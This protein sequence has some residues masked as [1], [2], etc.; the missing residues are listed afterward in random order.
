MAGYAVSFDPALRTRDGDEYS[1]FISAF[2]G[3]ADLGGLV[4]GLT[5][6]QTDLEPTLHSPG[7]N[8]AWLQNARYTR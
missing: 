5:R 2:G 3:V 1:G 4:A 7:S 8:W 6:S